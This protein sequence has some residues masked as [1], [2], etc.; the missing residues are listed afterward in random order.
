MVSAPRK[1]KFSNSLSSTDKNS[2]M[3]TMFY[4]RDCSL[5][6]IKSARK[7]K[8]FLPSARNKNAKTK[9]RLSEKRRKRLLS[10]NE[11][12]TRR[13]SGMKMKPKSRQNKMQKTKQKQT[14]WRRK[15]LK[16]IKRNEKKLASSKKLKNTCVTLTKLDSTW[17]LMKRRKKCLRFGLV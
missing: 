11:R 17:N 6:L 3:K 7:Q 14:Q 4:P 9:K 12:M 13:K 10:R 2:K 8:R 1:R 15:R 5:T 16:K